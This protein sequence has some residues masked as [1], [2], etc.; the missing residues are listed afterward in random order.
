MKL[1]N[2]GR[3]KAAPILCY[4]WEDIHPKLPLDEAKQAV[5]DLFKDDP[6][7]TKDYVREALQM[8]LA[9]AH[10]FLPLDLS[11]FYIRKIEGAF[12]FP[13]VRG[14][15]DLEVEV[16][17]GVPGLEEHAGRTIVIDWKTTATPLDAA[18]A[19][20]YGMS[21]QG[22]IYGA[23]NVL[24]P[25][26][27]DNQP[28]S[29][30]I[31]RGISRPLLSSTI[32]FRQEP[33]ELGPGTSAEVYRE[34]SQLAAIRETLR[35]TIPPDMPWPKARSADVCKKYRK[36]CPYLA[37]CHNGRTLIGT[38]PP[39]VFSF[40]SAETFRSCPE[41]HRLN[42]L[43]G[44]NEQSESSYIGS[45]VHRGLEIIYRAAKNLQEAGQFPGFSQ[46]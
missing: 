12:E 2:L 26:G 45:M 18:W 33:L 40:T 32:N 25:F 9:A 14:I 37:D 29:H 35:T 17:P 38:P 19:S 5:T 41:R 30:I 6:A 31:F 27:P 11:M 39:K 20:K 24:E 46:P 21:W 4:P 10:N 16:K 1:V 8:T 13:Y 36:E 15:R 23:A 7:C 42:S 22:L 28:A 44:T 3:S 34:F 43:T